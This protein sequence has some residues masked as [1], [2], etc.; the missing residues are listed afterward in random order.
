MTGHLGQLEAFK[1]RRFGRYTLKK[2]LTHAAPPG[3]GTSQ[4]RPKQ[5]ALQPISN[6]RSPVI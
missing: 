2:I 3:H 5:A 1:R 4:P 6:P